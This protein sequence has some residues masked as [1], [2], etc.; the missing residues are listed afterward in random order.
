[1]DFKWKIKS[2]LNKNIGMHYI[3]DVMQVYLENLLVKLG[4]MTA[5]YETSVCE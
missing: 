5:I 1:M 3:R 4:S 2:M